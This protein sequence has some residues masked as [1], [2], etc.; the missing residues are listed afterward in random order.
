MPRNRSSGNDPA[1]FE[2]KTRTVNSVDVSVVIPAFTRPGKL[3]DSLEKI[4]ACD[5]PPREIL[6]HVDDDNA[7]VKAA[8]SESSVQ[9]TP[10]VSELRIGPGGGRNRLLHEATSTYVASFDDDSYP[11]QKDYFQRAVDVMEQ[12]PGAGAERGGKFN[13][14]KDDETVRKGFEKTASWADRE[15][16]DCQKY[17]VDMSP[18]VPFGQCLCGEPKAKHSDEALAAR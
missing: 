13:K 2:P 8:L 5:P 6:V 1:I 4:A 17:V 15:T 3:V 10:V 11:T 7:E 14:T 9:V 16:V 12:A 18:G